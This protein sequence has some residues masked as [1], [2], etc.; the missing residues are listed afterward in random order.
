MRTTPDLPKDLS[1]LCTCSIAV[2][3]LQEACVCLS[4]TEVT[5]SKAIRRI[6]LQEL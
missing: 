5:F 1:F 2:L 6:E 4:V 3:E